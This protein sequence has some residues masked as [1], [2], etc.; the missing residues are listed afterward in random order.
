WDIKQLESKQDKTIVEHVHVLEE[1]K[2][3]TDRQLAEAQD[4]LQKNAAYIRSLEKAKLRLTSEAEDLQRETERVRMELRGQEKATA[5]NQ[6]VARAIAEAERERKS[7]EEAELQVRRLQIELQKTSRHTEDLSLQLQT[8]QKSKASLEAELDRLVDETPAATSLGK[9]QRQYQTR[10]AQLEEQIAH[11]D[12]ARLMAMRRMSERIQRQNADLRKL[13]ME[14]SASDSTF[15]SRL[16]RELQL[17]DDELKNDVYSKHTPITMNNVRASS[18]TSTSQSRRN[19]SRDAPRD[20]PRTSDSQVIALK[21]QVQVLELQMA[22]SERVRHHL[23]TSIREMTA[24]IE[25]SDGSKQFLQQYRS[26]LANENKRLGELLEEEAEARRSA[27]AAQ[28]DGIQAVWTKFQKTI[29]DERQSY[30]QL[31]ESRKALVLQQ[32]NMHSDLEIQ[33]QQL[34]EASQAKQIVESMKLS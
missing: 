21:Q 29:D 12:E 2:R 13:V 26:R 20:A 1:A 7:R 16:L 23:E 31:E 4:E 15:Q 24:D 14:G 28:I 5:R 32:R 3:V 19:S 8:A 33:R 27:E 9:V 25:N 34:S 10:I 22:A 17:A 11:A 30:T 6:D 18:S